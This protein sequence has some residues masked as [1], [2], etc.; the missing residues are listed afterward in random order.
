[1]IGGLVAFAIAGSAIHAIRPSASYRT[2]ELGGSATTVGLVAASFSVV[3][4]ALAIPIGRVI[5]RTEPR[6]FFIGGAALMS[7]SAMVSAILP[8]VWMLAVGQ[9]GVGLGWVT[10]AISYQT[11]TANRSHSDRD[12]GFARLAVAASAAQLVGPLIAGFLLGLGRRHPMWGTGSSLAFAAA[13]CL[14]IAGSLLAARSMPRVPQGRGSSYETDTDRVPLRTILRQPGVSQALL[15]GVAVSSG[16]DLTVIY[17]PLIGE[18]RGVDVVV[19]GILLSLRGA[20]SLLSRLALPRMLDRFGRKPLLA[21]AVVG[22]GWASLGVA[23]MSSPMILGALVFFFGY[24]LGL[25][26]P[27]TMAWLS[28]QTP[29]EQRGTAL[30]MRM[31]GNRIGQ[32]VLPVGVGGV[33]SALG[34]GVV[35]VVI[36]CGLLAS[37]LVLR[38]APIDS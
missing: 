18:A 30:A 3:A 29:R 22:A 4:V 8:S 25:G 10:T 34:V 5:D 15:L 2:L 6:R 21:A 35:F 32:V 33:A 36:G 24:G 28:V 14:A 1:M 38:G 31:T 27:L 37:A 19:V 26:T 23:T 16:L 7:V 9:V 11:I 17:L 20:G 13:A 12:R